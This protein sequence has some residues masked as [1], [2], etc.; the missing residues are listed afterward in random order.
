MFVVPIY[1]A[2]SNLVIIAFFKNRLNIA[3]EF[4]MQNPLNVN[5]KV[6]NKKPGFEQMEKVAKTVRQKIA[7]LKW[8]VL[9]VNL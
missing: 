1:V 6:G 4:C 7:Q 5:D 9:R 8:N 3:T 2:Q